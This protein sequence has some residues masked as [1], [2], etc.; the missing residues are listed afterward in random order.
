M[1]RQQYTPVRSY[2]VMVEC[3]LDLSGGSSNWNLL[4]GM[5]QT[6]TSDP[7]EGV[8][9]SSLRRQPF[10]PE[11]SALSRNKSAHLLRVLDVLYTPPDCPRVLGGPRVQVRVRLST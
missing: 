9:Y 7:S 6:Q 8:Y 4:R 3:S 5:S 11:T 10:G 2:E 1:R